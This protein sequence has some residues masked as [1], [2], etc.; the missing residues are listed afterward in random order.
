MREVWLVSEPRLIGRL[1]QGLAR[2]SIPYIHGRVEDIGPELSWQ[3]RS[4]ECGCNLFLKHTIKGLRNPIML[5]LI[6]HSIVDADALVVA[7]DA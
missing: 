6:G 2:A 7:E 5:M 1:V 4:L 3:V